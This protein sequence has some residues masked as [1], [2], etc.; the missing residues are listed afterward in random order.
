MDVLRRGWIRAFVRGIV[1]VLSVVALGEAVSFLLYVSNVL[2]RETAG[3]AAQQG[4]ILFY[5]FHRVALNV[6]T[7][8]LQ[9]PSVVNGAIGLPSGSAISATLGLALMSG[10]VVACWLFV[11]AGRA[12]GRA[13]GG[14]PG[15]R[16]LQGAKV[17][18]PYASLLCAG[19][20]F[21]ELKQKF[22][23]SSLMVVRPSHL[24]A[25]IWP[26]LFGAT[27]GAIGGFRSSDPTAIREWLGWRFTTKWISRWRGIVAGATTTLV[28][29][30]AFAFAGLIALAI[31]DRSATSAYFR[32]TS[33]KGVPSGIAIVVLTALTIPNMALWVL[34]PAMGGCLEV[35]GAGTLTSAPSPYC[36]S[37]YS[38]SLA[39]PLTT[40][41]H[42]WGFLGF[43]ELGAPSS[44]YLLFLLVPLLASFIG[45]VRAARAAE[46]DS[47][48]EAVFITSLSAVAFAVL[49]VLALTVAWVT[50]TASGAQLVSNN[51]IRYGPYP[52]D[53]AQL[54]LG[55][56]LIAGGVG[57]LW[58]HK[59]LKR[60]HRDGPES[61]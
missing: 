24:S 11:R 14:G 1:V 57:G 31:F 21:V 50:L 41:S 9:L 34:V 39:H 44:W 16:A 37:S 58:A 27:F 51:Y 4:L 29:S 13:A 42:G 15:E 5:A 49:M 30:A 26:L 6:N 35:G 3:Q 22:P 46:A 56:G 40:A 18:L 59:R 60:V 52:L 43:H 54:A 45:G 53:G 20:W 38:N 19:S 7:V 10:T 25:F 61:Q 8:A 12:V 36:F 2:P 48:R 32:A 47:A 33:I 28:L 55:W 17:A 23:Q